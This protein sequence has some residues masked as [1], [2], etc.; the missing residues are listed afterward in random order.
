MATLNQL[1]QRGWE[2]GIL[3]GDHPDI[4]QEVAQRFGI[5]HVQAGVTPEEKLAVIET[6]NKQFPT[7]VMVGDGVNDSAALAAATVGIVVHNGA[8]AS[9]AA[10]PVYLGEAGLR[11]IADLLIASQSTC[12]AIRRNLGVSLM[13]NAVGASLAMAGLLHPLLAAVLMPISSIT[14]IGLSLRAGTIK[15]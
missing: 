1:R 10:A 4:V 11:P 6:A 5:E 7:T 15:E 2:L 3:S 8:E 9:L 13:Y 12:F 14:V